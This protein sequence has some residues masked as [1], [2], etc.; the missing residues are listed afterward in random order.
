MVDQH[1]YFPMLNL[2]E[3][4]DIKSEDKITDYK[5]IRAIANDGI[6]LC[7]NSDLVS[8]EVKEKD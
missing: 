1:D 6:F 5:Y 7:L 8:G 4:T 2:K 3:R